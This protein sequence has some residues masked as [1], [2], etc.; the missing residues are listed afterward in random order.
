VCD[1]SLQYIKIKVCELVDWKKYK[2]G[3]IFS[4]CIEVMLILNCQI[5]NMK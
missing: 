1:K 4:K 2:N 5:A 3:K